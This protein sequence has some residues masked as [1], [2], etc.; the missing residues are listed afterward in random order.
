MVANWAV[1]GRLAESKLDLEE[2][3]RAGEMRE[4]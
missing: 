4:G 2:L 3:R 1:E